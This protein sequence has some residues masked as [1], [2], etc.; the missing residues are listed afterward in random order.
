MALILAGGDEQLASQPSSQ[1]GAIDEVTVIKDADIGEV[2]LNVPPRQRL[3]GKEKNK[4]VLKGQMKSNAGKKKKKSLR[5]ALAFLPPCGDQEMSSVFQAF[6]CL[7]HVRGSSLARM[8]TESHL[9]DLS[10]ASRW[11]PGRTGS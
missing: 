3:R 9:Y 7:G 5:M 2:V 10:G 6:G 11:C 8:C 4:I 1:D